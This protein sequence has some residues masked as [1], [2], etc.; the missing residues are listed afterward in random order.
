MIRSTASESTGSES[1]ACNGSGC[2]GGPAS[3][4]TLS[5][6]SG[7]P[8]RGSPMTRRARSHAQNRGS[9][10]HWH[11]QPQDH[12][13]DLWSPAPRGGQLCSM[14]RIASSV[15]NAVAVIIRFASLSRAIGP[16]RGSR[17]RLALTQNRRWL[18]PGRQRRVADGA[19]AAARRNV[20][21][22]GRRPSPGLEPAVAAR[23]SACCSRLDDTFVWTQRL[24]WCAS[25]PDRRQGGRPALPMALRPE[26][27]ELLPSYAQSP[28]RRAGSRG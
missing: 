19:P 13:L 1:T 2:T 22:V 16:R 23:P 26:E 7:P 21:P 24:R 6:R 3:T 20:G 15:D 4:R 10:P 8:A 11:H 9:H 25:L 28:T 27:L 5:T 18:R 17:A 14:R 12:A